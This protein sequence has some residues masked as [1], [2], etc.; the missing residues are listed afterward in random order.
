MYTGVAK[1]IPVPQTT[2]SYKIVRA[3]T[4]Y[5]YYQSAYVWNAEKNTSIVKK[6]EAR[7]LSLT[8]FSNISIFVFLII[9]QIEL[10]CKS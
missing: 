3:G 8:S 7:I 2:E 10:S 4:G 9:L 1:L 5:V 6:S